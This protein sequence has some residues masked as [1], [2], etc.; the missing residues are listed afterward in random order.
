MTEQLKAEAFVRETRPTLMELTRGCEVM[1]T[2][3][4]KP[5][6]VSTKKN[7]FNSDGDEFFH[8]CWGAVNKKIYL[9]PREYETQ[10]T[11]IIG[12]PIQLQDWLAVLAKKNTRNVCVDLS[13]AE[14]GILYF[15]DEISHW[16]FKFNLT[17][18]QPNSPEDY[19]AFNEIVSV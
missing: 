1:V 12:H 6:F 15:E 18:G 14:G 5:V 13:Q 17:T 9:K 11:K 19:K 2:N 3:W 7:S 16:S 8:V 4:D 10:I